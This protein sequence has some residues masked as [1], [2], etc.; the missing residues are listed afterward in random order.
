MSSGITPSSVALLTSAP[1]S[2]SAR[3]TASWPTSAAINSGVTPSSVALLTCAP[4][5]ISAH[6]IA[7]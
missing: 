6:T 4:N 7:S 5:S 3:T 1:N 2:I